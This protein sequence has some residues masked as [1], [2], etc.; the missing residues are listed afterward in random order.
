MDS[1]LSWKVLYIEKYIQH[2]IE[3]AQPQYNDEDNF[4]EITTLCSPYIKKLMITQ[5]QAWKPPLTWEKEDIPEFYPIDHINIEP[6]LAKLCNIEELGI[7]YGSR[8]C[9]TSYIKTL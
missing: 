1:P 5:L 6:I 9:S 7:I 3:E 8:K 2:L 4:S